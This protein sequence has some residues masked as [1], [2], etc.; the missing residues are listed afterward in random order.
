MSEHTRSIVDDIRRRLIDQYPNRD[1]VST[2]AIESCNWRIIAAYGTG[3]R[4]RVRNGRTGEE[5]TGTVSR[6]T[7]WSPSLMLMA[8]SDS[9]GSSDLLGPDDVVVA[10]KAS[11]GYV[12]V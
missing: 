12:P 1:D 3:Q 10:Y 6:T 7:G 4:V 5:R 11:R 2:D 8:R 9:R